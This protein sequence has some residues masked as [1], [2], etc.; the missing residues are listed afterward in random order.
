MAENKTPFEK[1]YYI[2]VSD[3]VET[4]KSGKTTLSYLSWTWAWA[5]FAKRF[6][7]ATYEIEKF[8]APDGTK[9]PYIYDESTGY[10]VFTNVTIDGLTHEMWLPV[11]DG[12]NK[13]MKSKPYKYMTKY[14]GEKS[15]EA[16]SMFDV[17]KTIMR[18]LVK[19]LAMFG[20]G[21]YIYSGEDLP[22][23][24]E[25]AKEKE[26]A[27]FKKKVKEHEKKIDALETT[28]AIKKYWNMLPQAEKQA[29]KD[30]V[31]KKGEALKLLKEKE[32]INDK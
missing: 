15:V 23:V 18:C 6:P 28:D 31:I 3:N 30:F 32:E 11:M 19:N 9:R 27:A 10:M 14:N 1:L 16:A 5:E 7:S 12:A 20:L 8:E 4:K 25:E 17:N 29:T 21:L 13:A 2:D 26:V 22:E 24:D